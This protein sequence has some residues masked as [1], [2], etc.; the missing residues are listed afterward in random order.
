MPTICSAPTGPR[1]CSTGSTWDRLLHGDF[2]TSWATISFFG[3]STDG[4]PVGPMV[5]RA[6]LVT[7]SLLIGGLR[8]DPARRGSA[9]RL[10]R[11]APALVRRPVVGRA[12]HR[13][14]LDASARRRV[15]V[16]AVRRQ[17]VETAPCFRLLHGREAV[18]TCRSGGR[19]FRTDG[20][21][22]PVRRRRPVG[23]ALAAAVADVRAVLRRALH[24]D[25]ACAHARG[26]RGTM[27]EDCAC[28]GRIGGPRHSR[29]T[30]CGTRSRRS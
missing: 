23:V 26:A 20:G 12:R 3:G 24:A 7:A 8:A 21:A 15:A 11:D 1:S 27:G 18:G 5:W 17:P 2:G 19:P 16:A 25:R 28:Q 6:A 29:R 22:A 10:R 9:R 4:S 30:P 14:D 13:G